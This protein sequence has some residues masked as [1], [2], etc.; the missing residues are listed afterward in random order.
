[1]LTF[2]MQNVRHSSAI[3]DFQVRAKMITHTEGP[4]KIN[5]VNIFFSKFIRFV[6][7][8]LVKTDHLLT[9]STVLNEYK[10][11]MTLE[12]NQS[13]V[14]LATHSQ[15]RL[16]SFQTVK[17]LFLHCFTCFCFKNSVFALKLQKQS[18]YSLE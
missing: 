13:L 1:M 8:I 11:K 18:L 6:L 4:I 7:P 2:I 12:N 15:S 17:T 9:H 5:G 10:V 3:G 14:S 16:N